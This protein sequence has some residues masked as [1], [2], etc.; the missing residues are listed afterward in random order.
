MIKDLGMPK[1][2]IISTILRDGDTI[3]PRGNVTLLEGDRLIICARSVR[4]DYMNE[5]K[6][7]ELRKN[8]KWNGKKLKEL[9]LSRQSFIVLVER[10]RKM[11]IPE[12]ELV[13]RTGDRILM[14]SNKERELIEDKSDYIG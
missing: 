5:L 2:A 7:I 6:E 4:D 1:N 9:D 3:I 8:H 11:I 10:N 14:Y 12:G 13:L